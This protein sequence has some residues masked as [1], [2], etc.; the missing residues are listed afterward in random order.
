[1]TLSKAAGAF[2]VAAGCVCLL[3]TGGCYL[4]DPGAAH[5]AVAATLPAP[6][7]GAT[8]SVK[9]TEVQEALRLIDGVLVS[10]SHPRGPDP[11]PP[12]DRARGLVASYGIC[13]VTLKGDTVVVGSPPP[14][15]EGQ[16]VQIAGER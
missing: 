7:N 15:K 2:I 4:G 6:P 13:G 14:L 8:L 10:N 1:M 5:G 12:E 3:S 16:A 11:L 9:D